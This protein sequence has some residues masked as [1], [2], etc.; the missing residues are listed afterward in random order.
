MVPVTITAAEPVIT[1]TATDPGGNTSAFDTEAVLNAKIHSFTVE[2]L[3]LGKA[4]LNWEVE[5]Q[6]THAYF[7]IEHQSPTHGF[8][9]IG[10]QDKYASVNQSQLYQFEVENLAPGKHFFRV[11]QIN[12]HGSRSYSRSLGLEI[13]HHSPHQLLIP[14]PMTSNSS[15]KIRV[16]RTQKIQVHLLSMS[17]KKL[18]KIFSGEIEGGTYQSISLEKL[19]NISQGLYIL[20]IEGINFRLNR[21]AIVQ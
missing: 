2:S 18:S 5:G 4:V 6:N 13:T 17:G 16:Q 19:S 7:E 14:N 21:K 10:R 1:A 8:I 15:M 3:P 9:K 12:E 20:S 11:A